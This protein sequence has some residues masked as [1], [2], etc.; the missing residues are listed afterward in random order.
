MTQKEANKLIEAIDKIEVEKPHYM[1]SHWVDK[2]A[3]E[4]LEEV[5]KLILTYVS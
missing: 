2:C 5:K 1:Y 4:V 3:G